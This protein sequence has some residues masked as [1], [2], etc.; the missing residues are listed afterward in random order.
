MNT[1][2]KPIKQKRLTRFTYLIGL[3]T[4]IFALA[5]KVMVSDS[6]AAPL[7]ATAPGLGAAGSFSVLAALSM[8]AAGPGTTV[9][10]DLGL[11]PGLAVSRTGPWTVGGSEHFGPGSLAGTAQTDALGAFNNLAGQPSSG[12][13]GGATTLVPGV[14][15][16]TGSPAFA[17]TITLNGG[18][19][20]VWV[21]QI[22]TD[23]TFAGSVV[24]AGGARACNVF[25]QIGRD[26]TIASGSAFIGTLIVSRD[27][28]LVSGA[29]VDGRVIS[30]NGAL[31][32]DG[33]NIFGPNCP[34]LPAGTPGPVPLPSYVSVTYTCAENGIIPITVGLS[35][36]VIVY[37]LGEAITSDHDTGEAKIVRYLPIGHYDWQA[38][39][40]EGHYMV[41]T[42]HG[43]IDG[44]ACGSA[45]VTAVPATPAS[46]LPTSAVAVTPIPPILIPITGAD[47][48]GEQELVSRQWAYALLGALGFGLMLIGVV[49][50]R[51][52]SR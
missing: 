8:S 17:G 3:F 23:F 40:P 7:S 30:L 27:V 51:K 15:T 41:D 5:L 46:P 31:T 1:F 34:A 11:S 14:W 48:A 4:L 44:V 19:T 12:T 33:N 43:A 10:G 2:D 9:G 45:S 29:S 50:R 36:G 35:A 39:P 38:V 49:L 6:Q 21:F 20:D 24:L 28:T 37:G 18:P 42:D 16:D 13:W 22:S 47:F 26:A 32:T 25:W 52:S